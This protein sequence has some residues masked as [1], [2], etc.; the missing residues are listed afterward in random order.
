MKAVAV[1]GVA[2]LA[3]GTW[4]CRAG[5]YSNLLRNASFEDGTSA[6][7]VTDWVRFNNC[8][9]YAYTGAHDGVT[10]MAAWGNW[11][12]SNPPQWNASGLYQQVPASEGQLFEASI[13]IKVNE[14]IQGQAYAGLVL[15]FYN[16]QSNNIFSRSCARKINASTVEDGWIQVK[17]KVR[18]T[19]NT[20]YVRF[21]PLFIQSPAFEAG[22][23]WFDDASLMLVETNMLSFAGRNWEVWDWISTPGENFF[24]KESV[25]K[26]TNGWLHLRCTQVSGTWYSAALQTTNS[27]GFGEYRW[28]L[29]NRVDLIDSNLVVGLFTYAQ[30][31]QYGTN[32]N[33]VDIEFSRAFPGTQTNWLVYTVQ[34]Y[35]VPGNT[36]SQPA[37][38]TNELTTHRFIWRPDG[39][40]WQSY[41]G[42]TPE[43][44]PG[45]VFGEWRF[46]GRDIPDETNEL[47]V[48]N[49][50]LFFTNAPYF[51]QNVEYI[52]RDFVFIPYDGFILEDRFDDDLTSNAWDVVGSTVDETGGVLAVTPP[53]DASA[54]GYVTTGTIHRTPRGSEF[55]FSALLKTVE[56]QVA[57]SGP[58]VRAVLAL[59][60]GTNRARDAASALQV[61]GD[62]DAAAGSLAVN[63]YAKTNSPNSDGTL[64]FRGILPGAAEEM[65]RGGIE[66]GIDLEVS[67][68]A[69]RARTAEGRALGW[70]TNVGASSGP[71]VLRETL[72]NA[73]WFVGGQNSAA[74]SAG[75]VVW[76]RTTV[77]V[78][79]QAEA[80]AIASGS[81][82]NGLVTFY[83]PSFFDERYALYKATTITG[84]FL[85][86]AT[87]LE[88]VVGGVVVTEAL[89]GAAG[90]YQLRSSPPL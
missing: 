73:Y 21:A 18:A 59:S 34:P 6:E 9:R 63:L 23:A 55:V 14:A 60:G 26:D 39:V 54:A 49:L 78:S 69:V 53:A 67:N 31:G 10:A 77:G 90:F 27:L 8:Y 46:L 3:C 57:R 30:E 2:L 22:A 58:D 5:L 51:T 89:D 15:E 28:H 48:M 80:P 17:G 76:D 43:P 7:D 82:S 44:E 24:G 88:S 36:E 42:H 29:G 83:A 41:Y 79:D 11:W 40:H 50:W 87:G 16:A 20:A 13:W 52:V 33:E 85:P 68:Y 25:F 47:C 64:L 71:H 35:N 38:L 84:D 19:L 72:T 45:S 86:V 74:D 81:I 61:F 70:V 66:L 12:P 37:V 62:Y 32:Q 1:L 65:G 4:A 56:V 75:V